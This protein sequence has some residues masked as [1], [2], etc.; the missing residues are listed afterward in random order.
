MNK[1]FI[2]SNNNQKHQESW[3]LIDA[4]NQK[5]GRLSTKIAY[6]LKGKNDITYTPHIKNKNYVIVINAKHVLVTGNKKYQ[7]IYRRHSGKPGSLKIENFVSLQ[8]RVPERIIEKSVKGMLPKNSLGSQLFSKLKVYED[9]N[10]PH[11]AQQPTEFPV[12]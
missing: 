1:T 6:V 9:N 8:N 12:K 10:H 4:R 7:K 5:L 11:E 3:Y 2:E